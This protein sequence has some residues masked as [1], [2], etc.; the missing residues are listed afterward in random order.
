MLSFNEGLAKE[1]FKKQN[2]NK[3]KQKKARDVELSP[4]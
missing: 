3:T 2:K 4:F 1:I